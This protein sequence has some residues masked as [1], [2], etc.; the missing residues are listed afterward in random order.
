MLMATG[1]QAQTVPSNKSQL[2][3]EAQVLRSAPAQDHH[4]TPWSGTYERDYEK[5][6]EL[7]RRIADNSADSGKLVAITAQQRPTL[8]TDSPPV[9]SSTGQIPEIGIDQNLT[10]LL[11]PGWF[12]LLVGLAFGIGGGAIASRFIS[13]RVN[14]PSLTEG[15]LEHVGVDLETKIAI[16]QSRYANRG[17][18]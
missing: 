17:A 14:Q 1:I 4:P 18:D 11:P 13:P 12:M 8:Q 6:S 5:G 2:E 16:V 10:E 3:K 7:F 15:N 9:Q